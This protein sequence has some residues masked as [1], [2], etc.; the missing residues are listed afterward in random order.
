MRIAVGSDHAGYRLKEHLAAR[1]AAAGADVL[2]LGT[3][4]EESCDYPE[5]GRAVA[6]AVAAGRADRGLVICGTG[7]G[8]SMAANRVPGVRAARCT[9]EYDARY[10]R[11]HNDA[12]VLALG[13]RVSGVGLA[14]AIVDTFL[15]TPFE[16]GRHQR[17]VE[18][19]DAPP[20][21]AD[22]ADGPGSE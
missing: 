16:G 9:S 4:S 18:Q 2:D 21:A 7:L 11:A 13:S 19:I 6:A 14:E 15:A 17:R 3:A 10:A 12:N 20:A 1:L 8:I 22:G 5:Y